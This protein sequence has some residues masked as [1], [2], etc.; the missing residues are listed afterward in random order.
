MEQNALMV[1]KMTRYGLQHRS[2]LQ[3]KSHMLPVFKQNLRQTSLCLTPVR[4]VMTPLVSATVPTNAPMTRDGD[5]AADMNKMLLNMKT[6]KTR[7]P[8][9]INPGY[10]NTAIASEETRDRLPT[11][12]NLM[13]I[14]ILNSARCRNKTRL[15]LR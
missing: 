7:N 11:S 1:D 14:N 5:S 15:M 10:C 4:S 13:T 3:A 8:Q 2:F 9:P 6:S 12:L